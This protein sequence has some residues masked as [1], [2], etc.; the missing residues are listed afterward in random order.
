MAACDPNNCDP[1]LPGFQFDGCVNGWCRYSSINP[2]FIQYSDRCPP[3]PGCADDEPED[4]ELGS[5]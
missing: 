3:S 4:A 5:V 2:P 1:P